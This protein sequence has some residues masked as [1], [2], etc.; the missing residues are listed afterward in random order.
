MNYKDSIFQF[1]STNT[2]PEI[3]SYFSGISRDLGA[4]SFSVYG[5]P[6]GRPHEAKALYSSYPKEWLEYYFKKEFSLIDPVHLEFQTTSESL[7]AWDSRDS[8]FHMMRE[9]QDFNINYGISVPVK[10]ELGEYL[11]TF[12]FEKKPNHIIDSCDQKKILETLAAMVALKI[13]EKSPIFLAIALTP[14]EVECLKWTS[15]G[16]TAEDIGTILSISDWTV[17]FHLKNAY[18]KLDACNKNSA[19]TKAFKLGLI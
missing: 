1:L 4:T 16:K 9:C 17:R 11:V 15:E 7:F 3:V 18:Q 12:S 13:Y 10:N 6:K 8:K 14:R 5:G 19:I 2:I